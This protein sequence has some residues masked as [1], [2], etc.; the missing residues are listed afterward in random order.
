MAFSSYSKD[1]AENA[2]TSIENRFITK[3]LPEA[4][5]EAVR[6]YL[7]GLYLCGLREDFDAESTAKILKLPTERIEE[8][9]TFWEE[10]G[11]VQ[12]LSRSPLYVEY[13]PVSASLG[14][15]KPIRPE[16]YT[17]FNRELF[18]LLQRAGKDIKAY[19]QQRVLE[20]LENNPM[21]PQAFLL[22]VEYYVKKQ[23]EK[24]TVAHVL[25]A[26]KKLVRE[27][28]LTYEQVETEYADF[29]AHQEELGSVFR[30]LGIYRKPQD[31]DYEF[32]EKWRKA[33]ME[34]NAVKAC[35]GAL[36]KG[37]LQ[38]LDL[39]VTELAERNI[40]TQTAAE[41]YLAERETLVNIV[42]R[43]ARKLGIKVGNPRPY[44]EEYAEKWTER[45]Y[46][47]ESLT[48]VAALG[49]R[50][51]YGFPELDTLLDEMY[52]EGIVDLQSVKAY[53]AKRDREFRLL[54]SIQSVCGVVKKTTAA[55]DM[56][57]VWRTW[58]FS[59]EM[60]LEAARRSAG[61]SAPLPYMNKLLSEWKRLGAFTPND[62]PEREAAPS[63]R[64]TSSPIKSEA[65]IAAD[66][67]Y[68]REHYYSVRRDAADRKAAQARTAAERDREF[69]QAESEIRS[70]EIEIA[71]AELY[72][73]DRLPSLKTA[74]DA[75]KAKRRNAMKRLG[76]TEEDFLPEYACKKCSDTG[77]LPDGRP[78]DC[79]PRA[80]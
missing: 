74:L 61:A 28:K 26:A 49:L 5:G 70:C 56:I 63:V 22:I 78:C 59:D 15:P 7:Y 53:C 32:L 27:H 62:I 50:L 21:D 9:Y 47:E 43:V 66:T 40:F 36:K 65:A 14:K 16:R 54:Q 41:A 23:G 8:I 44:I 46:D 31:A 6:V 37:T 3:Y 68:E 71:K 13:L 55:L 2:F 35:A 67:R 20:F 80:K 45:G 1:F 75:A 76:L 29:N 34:A 57:A 30:L 17:E 60:I 58:S 64:T 69:S 51:Q 73:S 72:S 79:Y 12:I 52:V 25:N 48:L 18:K 11:L 10:C 39:L 4:N 42:Y 38:T 33:G 24:L 77:F 19:E